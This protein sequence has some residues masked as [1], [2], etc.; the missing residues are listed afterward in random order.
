MPENIRA[1][2]IILILSA[3]V[4]AFA[5]R[6]ASEMMSRADFVRRRNLWFTITAALFIASDVWLFALITG[7]ILIYQG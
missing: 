2:I 5:S 3:M 1:L 7:F 6:P 4:F